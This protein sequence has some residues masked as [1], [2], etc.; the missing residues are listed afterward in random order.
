MYSHSFIMAL[1]LAVLTLPA[2]KGQADSQANKEEVNQ[3]TLSIQQIADGVYVHTGQ[4]VPI[5]SPNSDDIANIGFIVGDKCVAVIDTGGSVEI[6]HQLRRTVKATTDVPVC[7]VIDTHVHYDHLLGNLAFKEP[8]MEFI[9]HAQLPG[10]LAT[11]KEFFQEQF[12]QYLGKNPADAIIA[13]DQTVSDSQTIDLGN[14]VLEIQAWPAGHTSSDLTVYDRRTQT[15]W[16]AD[17]LFMERIPALDSSLKGWLNSMDK[18]EQIPAE[19][20]VPG[21]GPA[22]A[23]WPTAMKD[24]RRYLTTLLEETRAAIQAGKFLDTAMDT[25]AQEEAAKWQLA[26]QH[27]RRNISRAYRELEWE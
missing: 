11:S 2:C 24:Q 17:L 21:H 15:L 6:G 20:V 5:D 13:P 1:V 7:Y 8:G 23:P 19:R 22:S 3:P 12:P 18:L 27:H 9:G 4:H 10:A 14:R 16:A 25:V 26:D